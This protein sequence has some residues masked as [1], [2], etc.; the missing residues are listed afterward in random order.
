VDALVAPRGERVITLAGADLA[1]DI[2][3]EQMNEGAVTLTRGGIV[4][5][6]NQR[7][8]EIVRAPGQVMGAPLK[9]FVARSDVVR[10]EEMRDAGLT[11]NAR[12]DLTF[13][14][15]DGTPVPVAVSFAP[16]HADPAAEAI[17]VVGI[18]RDITDQKQAETERTRLAG[19]VMTAQEEERR[20]IA[21]ELHDEIGQS[22]TAVLVGLRTIEG[23]DSP[24]RSVELAQSLRETTARTLADV[25]RLW[26]GL[27]PGVLDDL[28]FAAAVERFAQDFAEAHGIR[29]DVHAAGLEADGLS[30]AV[31]ATAYRVVQEALNNVAQHARANAVTVRLQRSDAT[32]QVSVED[33][34]AG[35]KPRDNGRLG[36][37][38]MRE[39]AALLG[40]SLEVRSR[41][42][43]GTTLVAQFPV[44]RE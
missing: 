16:L 40:G 32:L 15:G 1:Y 9:R 21:R 37:R 13:R 42:G 14:C 12:G 27:H 5:Y 4:A 39:R 10:F 3:F 25:G 30:V 29:V 31:Q 36:L 38:G 11:G 35:F 24:R 43:K 44:N 28:G 20:R 17:G 7:L 33:D 6:C 8:A 18:I 34:G 41:V 19:L 26:R 23:A 2:L 22:L